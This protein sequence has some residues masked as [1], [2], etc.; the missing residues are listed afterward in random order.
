MLLPSVRIGINTH[1]NVM[2][3]MAPSTSMRTAVRRGFWPKTNRRSDAQA[4]ESI[5]PYPSRDRQYLAS[6]CHE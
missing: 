5:R 1:L 4:A 2:K 3:L 6:P